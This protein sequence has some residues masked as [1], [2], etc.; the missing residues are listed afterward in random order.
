LTLDPQ[1]ALAY[2]GLADARF[3]LYESSRMRNTPN[4]DQLHLAI[5][6][7]R[8]AIE[9]DAGIGDAPCRAAVSGT[10]TRLASRD[11]LPFRRTTFRRM[12]RSSP[13]TGPPDGP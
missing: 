13:G 7:A 1:Y 2:A 11:D 4:H 12:D 10:Q 6:H 8:R 9:L 5:G 3:W